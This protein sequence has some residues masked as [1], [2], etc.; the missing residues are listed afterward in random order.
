MAGYK[1][2]IWVYADWEGI[3]VPKLMGKL[4]AE[5]L[6]GKE[7]FSFEY[8]PDWIKSPHS[9]ILDP[10]LQLYGGRLLALSGSWRSCPSRIPMRVIRPL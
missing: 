5:L 4:Q 3:E 8:N 6:R 2:S 10:D 1:K 7:I 9:Q